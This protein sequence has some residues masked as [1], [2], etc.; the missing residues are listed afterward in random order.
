MYGKTGPDMTTVT[1]RP[2]FRGILPAG[3][4]RCG[5]AD[6]QPALSAKKIMV[7]PACRCAARR[8][9]VAGAGAADVAAPPGTPHALPR[10]VPYVSASVLAGSPP[11]LRVLCRPAALA[12]MTGC[13]CDVENGMQGRKKK[14]RPGQQPACKER[15]VR[16][17][18]G[19]ISDVCGLQ[20]DVLPASG[21]ARSGWGKIP[22][23]PVPGP[24]RGRACPTLRGPR[25]CR[26][27]KR[28]AAGKALP[29]QCLGCSMRR[30]LRG[31]CGQRTVLLRPLYTPIFRPKQLIR[32][33][34][35]RHRSYQDGIRSCEV[36]CI[37]L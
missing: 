35:A 14:R 2:R 21:T 16:A 23:P 31:C 13:V 27:W 3:P 24:W 17:R 15:R 33:R 1:L 26:L 30:S 36:I 20:A 37:S 22:N 28:P 18:L 7:E 4:S 8:G 5:L 25:G 34:A 9:A 6:V 29:A 32:A 12:A 11:S 19:A 10:V